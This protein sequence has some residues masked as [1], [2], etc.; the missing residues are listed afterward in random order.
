MIKSQHATTTPDHHPSMCLV[1]QSTFLS[2][3]WLW[4][5]HDLSFT[6]PQLEYVISV[7]CKSSVSPRSC[8]RTNS[9][10]FSTPIIHSQT[11]CRWCG[12]WIYLA[13]F[14]A[15][16]CI[17]LIYQVDVFFTALHG[18]QTRSSDLYVCLSVH[19]TRELWTDNRSQRLSH[20]TQHPAKSSINTNGKSPRRFS[21]SL[22]WSS[23]VFPKPP[24]KGGGG[25]KR[26]LPS[27]V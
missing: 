6:S 16:Y 5:L 1:C 19:Q 27:F 23:Y 22:R 17:G 26:K 15:R 12:M 21:M 24:P 2:G 25:H 8:N 13:V 11:M 18:M 9:S 10:C 4:S 7:I 14:L 20:N 3:C